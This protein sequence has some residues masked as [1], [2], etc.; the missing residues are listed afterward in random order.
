MVPPTD[1][2]IRQVSGGFKVWEAAINTAP[3]QVIRMG[4][5]PSRSFIC[6]KP[7]DISNSWLSTMTCLECPG[8]Q[9]SIYSCKVLAMPRLIFSLSK[10]WQTS[11]PI[12]GNIFNPLF[13][14]SLA[15]QSI[16]QACQCKVQVLLI[17]LEGYHTLRH[18]LL[19][20]YTTAIANHRKPLPRNKKE[21]QV[22]HYF[23]NCLRDIRGN[24]S[25]NTE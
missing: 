21:L 6:E 13:K 12:L 11:V 19:Y 20:I 18:S 1:T 16:S 15:S 7:V 8:K 9:P 5:M 25:E 2:R 23:F 17:C 3:V 22:Q 14:L 4:K 10:T 24:I